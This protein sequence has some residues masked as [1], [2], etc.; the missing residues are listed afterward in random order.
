M[1]T[2]QDGLPNVGRRYLAQYAAWKGYTGNSAVLHSCYD[3]A[4]RYLPSPAFDDSFLAT[5]QSHKIKQHRAFVFTQ[6]II[7]DIEAANQFGIQPTVVSV[8]IDG[9]F[10]DRAA[11]T[12]WLQASTLKFDMVMRLSCLLNGMSDR[13]ADL[14][15][16][17]GWM[18]YDTKLISEALMSGPVEDEKADELITAWK[19]LQDS[20]DASFGMSYG[21]NHVNPNIAFPTIT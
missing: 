18:T 7:S 17:V 1:D 2:I 10:C 12:P 16:G 8:G 14:H 3:V 4:T 9:W 13:F 20:K 5:S 11:I 21:R 15:H 6:A 19:L